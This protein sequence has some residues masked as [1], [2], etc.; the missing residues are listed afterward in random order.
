MADRAGRWFARRAL[1]VWAAALLLSAGCA[2]RSAPVVPTPATQA[3]ESLPDRCRR[4][5]S[6]LATAEDESA[7]PR[8]QRLIEELQKDA[9]PASV[10]VLRD[11]LLSDDP[12]TAMK[13]RTIIALGRIGTPE[14]GTAY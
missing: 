13:R 12:P 8:M 11:F 3:A 10:E 6:V 7:L 9:S 5:L 14:A 1:Q 2:S 4:E